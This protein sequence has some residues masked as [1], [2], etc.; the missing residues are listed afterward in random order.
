MIHL[1]WDDVRGEARRVATS[2]AGDVDAVFG[3]PRGG[4]PVAALVAGMMDLPLVE[5]P[6]VG[7]CLVLDDLVDSGRTLAAFDGHKTDA[8]YRKPH[9]PAELAPMG[10][11][12][13]G[14]LVFPWEGDETVAAE[15]NVV[16]LLQA[17]GEDP[18]REGLVDTPARV[19]R[20]LQEM[21][22]G[23][24]VSPEDL[25]ATVFK[26]D[27]YDE[28]VVV[29]GVPFQSLCEHHLLPFAGHATVAYIPDGQV[30][31][32]SKLARLVH[33]FARRLQLQEALTS[34]IAQ[35][36]EHYLSPIGVGVIL[37][38]HHSCMSH[39]GVRSQ[40]Q[41]TTSAM[42][43]ALRDDPSARSELLALHKDST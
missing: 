35:A 31:G 5:E 29:S 43:G 18:D 33:C 27:D 25:L 32:L 23:A 4:I 1:S 34:Q 21:T 39:R 12:L 9:S 16:R 19:V 6:H 40:G 17:I 3:V 38:A 14:W 2:W 11:E 42:L 20:A 24:E 36:L 22:S 41:M 37:T 8:L 10:K 30:V 28:M 13:D 26:G 7:R 15:T